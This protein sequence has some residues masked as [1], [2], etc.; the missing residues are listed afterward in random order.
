MTGY[1]EEFSCIMMLIK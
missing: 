1:K